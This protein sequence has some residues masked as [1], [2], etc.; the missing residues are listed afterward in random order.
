MH[1]RVT[2]LAQSANHRQARTASRTERLWIE[3]GEDVHTAG[4][5]SAP[6]HLIEVS[7]P[8]EAGQAD[9][10]GA[11]IV[12]CTSLDAFDNAEQDTS[13]VPEMYDEQAFSQ[14]F[15]RAEIISVAL[16]TRDRLQGEAHSSSS[17]HSDRNVGW[18]FGWI[19]G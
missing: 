8:R 12:S 6:R 17:E 14:H 9:T 4:K 10:N 5:E 3:Q 2:R 1:L 7:P 16:P 19:G 15:R 18:P 11:Q 13:V